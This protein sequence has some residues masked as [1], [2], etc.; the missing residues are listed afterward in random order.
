MT[1]NKGKHASQT[2]GTFYRDLAIM[3]VGVIL[4]GAAVFFLLYLFADE[5]ATGPTT[6]STTFAEPTST[7]ADTSTTDG[8]STTTSTP[9]TTSSTSVDV[10]PPS[11]VTV[12]VL[13]SMGLDGAASEKTSEL[14]EAGY[15]TLTPDNYE[16]EQDPSRIWYREGFAPEAAVLLEH[17]PGAAVEPIPDESIGEGADVVLVLGAGYGG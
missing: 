3:I 17:L 10:R 13:N 16:P 15:Q 2:P 1:N 14:S 7:I 9:G 8:L 5:P 6:T 11:E 12:V 4:V